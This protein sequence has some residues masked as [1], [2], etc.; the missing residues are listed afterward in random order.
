MSSLTAIQSRGDHAANQLEPGQIEQLLNHQ[1]EGD[2]QEHRGSGAED[3]ADDTLTPR[4]RA[5]C[6]RNHNRIV[7]GENDIDVDDAQDGKNVVGVQ[8]DKSLNI[9]AT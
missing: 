9:N 3:D 4:Q 7:A 2:A 8:A 6:E 1:R 5:A